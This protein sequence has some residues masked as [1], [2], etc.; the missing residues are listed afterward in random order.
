MDSPLVTFDGLYRLN[1]YKINGINLKDIDLCHLLREH[2]STHLVL[3]CNWGLG[4]PRLYGI[5]SVT[6][7]HLDALRS[8]EPF[9]IS[10]CGTP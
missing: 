8:Q 3:A 1:D 10:A 4:F 9:K 7:H 2:D 6:S 5:D